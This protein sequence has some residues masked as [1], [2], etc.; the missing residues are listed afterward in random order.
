MRRTIGVLTWL[1]CGILVVVVGGMI[2]ARNRSA[3][4]FSEPGY[5]EAVGEIGK[6][7]WFRAGFYAH[8]FASAPVIFL[9][10]F[11][12]SDSFRL[13]FTGVHR[14]FGRAYVTLVLLLAAPGGLTLAA[15]AAGGP[16]AQACFVTM[17][18]LWFIFTFLAYRQ[19]RRGNIESHQAFMTRSFALAFGAIT[20]RLWM[21]LIGGLLEWRTPGAY[22]LCAWLSWVPNLLIVEAWIRTQAKAQ[23]PISA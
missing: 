20:L 10:W 9:G 12:F 1:I 11:Q 21:F 16:P 8:V 3:F 19:I 23:E 15:G 13:Q 5:L 6:A 4:W 7:A 14:W 2:I 18:V 17:S 22:A